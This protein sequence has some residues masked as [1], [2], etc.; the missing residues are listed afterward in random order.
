MKQLTCFII[1]NVF[2]ARKIIC[3]EDDFRKI[4]LD[5][6]DL[7]LL[8]SN[9]ESNS[10][11]DIIGWIKGCIEA[12]D[13]KYLKTLSIVLYQDGNAVFEEYNL[14]YSYDKGV[15]LVNLTL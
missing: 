10:I 5:T 9:C 12:I 8:D 13:K 1:S 4:P 14:N 15:G 11:G 3:S 2:Y 6:I 7:H